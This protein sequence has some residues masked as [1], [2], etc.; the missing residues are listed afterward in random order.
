[1][2]GLA[3]NRR[4][5]PTLG[6]SLLIT[7]VFMVVLFL[8]LT[9]LQAVSRASTAETS[10]T[11]RALEDEA[12]QGSPYDRLLILF[13]M[14]SSDPASAPAD[15][16]ASSAQAISVPGREVSLRL[17]DPEGLLD[18]YGD[19]L[20]KPEPSGPFTASII[21]RLT[22]FRTVG[23]VYPTLQASLASAGLNT[24]ELAA[25]LPLTTQRSVVVG[26]RR[27]NCPVALCGNV[28]WPDGVM[29][30]LQGQVQRIS[31]R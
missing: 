25:I 3:P 13:G 17:Q 16:F 9:A 14:A 20:P 30:I 1:V 24:E 18:I 7:L 8:M 19:P 21:D 6:A 15:F 22:H 10:A 5:S 29:P 28:S 4:R 23:S 11:I 12:H 26:L 31:V 27:E 2:S